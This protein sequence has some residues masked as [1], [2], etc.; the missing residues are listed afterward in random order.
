MAPHRN[1]FK[2][3]GTPSDIIEADFHNL[4]NKRDTI[5]RDC[6]YRPDRLQ[7]N[8]YPRKLRIRDVAFENVSLSKTTIEGIDFS[9]CTFSRC[10]FLGTMFRHCR[11]LNC[12]FVDSNMYRVEFQNV[13]IGPSSFKNCL[14]KKRHQNIG[15]HLYQELLRNSREQSQ[16]DF[17]D[18]AH[19]EFRRWQRY[20]LKWEINNSENITFSATPKFAKIFF[21]WAFEIT[22]GSGVRLTNLLITSIFGLAILSLLN[23]TYREEFGL[24]YSGRPI[25]SIAEAIYFSAIT[26]TT[27]GFGDIVPTTTPGRIAVT[28]QAVSGFT[29]LATLTSMIYRRIST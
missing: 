22:A 1:F 24:F 26:I 14:D 11:F 16:P 7:S 9:D 8:H 2:L 10:L 5:L 3:E 28:L 20:R 29:L 12:K 19:F 6:I 23:W 4:R 27:L 25:Q 13:F 18:E 17:A 21:S 15:L